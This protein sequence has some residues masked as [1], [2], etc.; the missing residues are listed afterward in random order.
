MSQLNHV[1]QLLLDHFGP[2]HWWPGDSPFEVMVGAVLTQNT[3][4]KNVELALRALRE[5]QALR[6]DALEAMSEERLAALIRPAGYYRLKARR[7]KNLVHYLHV[8]HAGSVE[9]MF[10]R[11]MAS[12]RDQLL[13]IDGIGPETA[14]SILL[15]AGHQPA[16]VVDTYTA[17]LVLRHGWLPPPAN[18]QRIQSHFVDNLPSDVALFNEFHALIVSLGKEFCRKQPRC[19]GCPLEPLLPASGP[20]K[21]T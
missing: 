6:P 9:A 7:L 8:Q 4:W 1:F 13:Q 10:S 19:A 11:D 16:F 2:Q 15:Y 17:R 3:S 14:D 18:Y 21:T 12:L 5:H 20:L